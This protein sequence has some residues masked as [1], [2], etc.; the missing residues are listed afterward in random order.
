MSPKIFN[1]GAGPA[2]LPLAILEAV[3]AELLDWQGSGLSILEVGHRTRPF[4]ALMEEAEALFRELLNIP[5]NYRVLFLGSPAR[6]QFSMIPMNLLAKDEEPAYLCSGTWSS[7]AYEEAKKVARAYAIS[8][9]FKR[10]DL[11]DKT[12][13]VYYT[14]N[15]T[16]EGIQLGLPD[17]GQH[18][19][20][21]DMT[22]CLLSEPIDV[23]QYGLIFAG[24]QKNIGPAGL[25]FVILRED[26]LKHVNPAIP[27]LLDYRVHINA[28]SLYATPP[29]FQ[30]YFALKMFQWIKAQGGLQALQVLNA[31]K[32]KRLY[33]YIDSSS[34]YHCA[35]QPHERSKMNV[36]FSLVD[37]VREEEFLLKAEQ[38][39]LYAL[40]GHRLVGGVRASLYNAMPMEGVVALIHYMDAFAAGKL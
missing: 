5:V 23:A 16:I 28:R 2:T 7:L 4:M 25:T 6:L 8:R 1:F 33:D 27:T 20:V 39:G 13:Y 34:F 30:C 18:C 17:V 32:S 19:L 14:P 26:I 12:T 35:V 24:A 3:Q 15:E 38:Q 36:C 9:D 40:R 31:E 21:A 29:T 10:Q 22:S 37:R 11:H